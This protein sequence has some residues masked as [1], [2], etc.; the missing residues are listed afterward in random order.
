M[1]V[2]DR[3]AV[4]PLSVTERHKLLSE[5]AENVNKIAQANTSQTMS[6]L[7]SKVQ[8]LYPQAQLKTF[9]KQN[10][11]SPT[12]DNEASRLGKPGRSAALEGRS[13]IVLLELAAIET[14]VL[15]FE[16]VRDQVVSQWKQDALRDMRTKVLERETAKAS[17]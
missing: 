3:A 15:S 10:S 9:E 4:T 8:E 17:N 11:L 13:S 1:E 7:L 6:V 14:P 5:A 2:F 12:L 16:S